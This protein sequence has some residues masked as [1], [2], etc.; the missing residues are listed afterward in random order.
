MLI[1][2]SYAFSIGGIIAN[3]TIYRQRDRESLLV[4]KL[5]SDIVWCIHYILISAGSGAATC[6]ISIC[7]E[8]VFLNKKH[9]WARHKIWL[10]V[11]I[12]CNFVSL[13]FT[14]K[15]IYSIL[16]GCTAIISIIVFWI[17]NP[18]IVRRIQIPIS[19]SFLIYNISVGSY[20]GIVNEVLSLISIFTFKRE[21]ERSKA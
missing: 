12:A 16:P 6:G 17:G 11:F 1:F 7:R 2:L 3:F 13:F 5:I 18:S 20:M 19:V 10:A 9:R 8:I 15:G 21:K 4:T 14:W